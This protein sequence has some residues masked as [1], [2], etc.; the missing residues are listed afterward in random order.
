MILKDL[1]NQLESEAVMLTPY[2]YSIK[3]TN[4]IIRKHF[5]MLTEKLNKYDV[6]ISF[7][8]GY[9]KGRED[10]IREAL[11]NIMDMK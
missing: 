2:S 8:E 1:Y 3:Q 11:Q 9:K 10:A 6:S 4:Q 7:D 5:K